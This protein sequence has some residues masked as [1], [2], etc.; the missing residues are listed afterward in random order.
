MDPARDHPHTRRC[1]PRGMSQGAGPVQPELGG[2]SQREWPWHRIS[3]SRA[4]SSLSAGSFIPGF[5]CSS[6]RPRGQKGAHS[7][8]L[9]IVWFFGLKLL[10]AFKSK[11]QFSPSVSSLY[12]DVKEV[13][14]TLWGNIFI[15]KTSPKDTKALA[16][17]K[18][19]KQRDAA[20]VA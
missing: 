20:H 18:V 12:K 8:G 15:Y 1:W 19:S 6:T 5:P 17:R 4:S 10:T 3:P 11:F 13:C 9:F 7:P 14:K 2:V 16:G